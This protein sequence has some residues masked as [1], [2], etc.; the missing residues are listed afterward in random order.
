MKKNKQQNKKKTEKKIAWHGTLFPLPLLSV[1]L[2]VRVLVI[3]FRVNQV[4]ELFLTFSNP[5]HAFNNRLRCIHCARC[6][7]LYSKII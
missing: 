7:P 6:V 5:R 4:C 1:L 2:A 3:S